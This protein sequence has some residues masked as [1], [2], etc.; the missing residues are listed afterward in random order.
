MK[1]FNTFSELS[2]ELQGQCLSVTFGNFD[3]VHRGHIQMINEFVQQAPGSTAKVIITFNPHPH[4]FFYK[5]SKYLLTT[6]DQKI[7]RLS[8]F[9]GIHI[10]ELCFDDYQQMK[11]LDFWRLLVH[12]LPQI[13][14]IKLGY[15]FRMG[16]DKK[17]PS[18]YILECDES[19]CLEK[20]SP[21]KLEDNIVSSSLIREKLS[22]GLVEQAA[23][24]LGYRFLIE[25][26]VVKGNQLGRTIGFPTINIRVNRNIIVPKFGVY[27]VNIKIDE[28]E[29]LGLLNVGSNPTVSKDKDI[30]FEAHVLN[31][32]ENVYDKLVQ[33]EFVSFIR[34]ERTFVSI[35]ELK[36]QIVKDVEFIN[37]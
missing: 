22:L 6:K 35:E 3:G 31:F 34:E 13:V 11:M 33:V 17:D 30:K 26:L 36:K 2:D 25:G 29:Y 9:E 7:D 1:V 8:R 14:Y 19:I 5:N 32:S 4:V 24:L 28:K 27:K 37:V 10:L 23:E 16:S 18:E 21:F 20:T 15:D 12:S